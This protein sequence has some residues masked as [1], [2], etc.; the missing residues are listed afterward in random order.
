VRGEATL[1]KPADQLH[2]SIAVVTDGDDAESALQSNSQKMHAVIQALQAKALTTKEYATG[3]FAIAPLYTPYP[4]DPPPNWTQKI[5]GYRVT[6]G[7][8][9]QT[10]KIELAGEL[11]DAAN[12]AGANAIEHISFGLQDERLYRPEIIRLATERA[13]QE[14]K[15][16]AAAANLKLTKVR[17]IWL[18]NAMPAPMPMPMPQLKMAAAYS[19]AP[20]PIEADQIAIN[21]NVTM[22]YEIEQ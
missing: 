6:N 12:Q 21:G 16:L 18:D 2:L 19:Q 4:K 10:S 15:E 9:I 7:L 20:T 1:Y 11:I 3:Q 17:H 22:V 8:K 13:M 5:I 14:A